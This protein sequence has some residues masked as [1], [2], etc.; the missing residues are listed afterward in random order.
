MQMNYK[1]FRGSFTT[2]DALF[3]EAAAFAT[4]LGETRVLSISHSCS[5]TDGVVTIKAP[6]CPELSV[7]LGK[8]SDKRTFCAIAWID[9][10]SDGSIKVTKLCTFHSDHVDCDRT[11]GWGLKWTAGSKD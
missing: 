10:L 6:G 5:G 11:Y 2:W 9:F 7:E 8:S 1:M 4:E 3:D